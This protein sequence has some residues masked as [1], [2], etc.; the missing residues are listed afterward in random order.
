MKKLIS[1][2]LFVSILVIGGCSSKPA[3]DKTT[4]TASSA[5]TL[6]VTIKDEVNNKELYNGEVRVD[7]SVKTLAAFLE[8]AD[9]LN[10]ELEDGQYGKTIMGLKGVKTEDFN[11]GPWWLYESA[12]NTACQA[13]G[14]CGAA[15]SLEIADG[16]QFTFRYTDS[17]E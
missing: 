7:G 2:L 10:A 3:E 16:D 9:E 6:S 13:A 14:M 1:A 11:T 12:N 5:T 8:K 17:F 15:D 4:S